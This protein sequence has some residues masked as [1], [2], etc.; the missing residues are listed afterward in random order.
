MKVINVHSHVLPS[1]FWDAVER[2]GHW[3]G[4]KVVT[5]PDGREYVDTMNRVAGP[6]D[7][8]W[9]YTPEE[10][11]QHMD[12]Q[13][14]DIH[15][16][17]VAPYLTNYHMEPAEGLASAQEL[18]NQIAEMARAHPDRFIGLATVPM[19]DS[20]AAA[21]ELERS[22]LEVGLKGVEINTNMEGHNLDE[23]QFQ[24]FFD[25]AVRL[26]AFVFVHPHNPGGSDRT[27]RN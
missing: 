17:S 2:E 19:Q 25:A 5:R 7:E 23:P 22:M 26:G 21:A 1:C 20:S 27:S 6:I 3:R 18:N 13:G 15:V 8:K 16:L 24:P 11:I 9:R 12:R 14:V 4:A 10:R